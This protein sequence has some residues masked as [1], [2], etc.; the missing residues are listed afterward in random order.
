MDNKI[1]FILIIVIL[2]IFPLCS[3]AKIINQNES[4]GNKNRRKRRRRRRR[5]RKRKRKLKN[6]YDIIPKDVIDKLKYSTK[7]VMDKIKKLNGGREFPD[8][9][10]Q[11]ESLLIRSKNMYLN[12]LCLLKILKKQSNGDFEK[13][14]KLMQYPSFMHYFFRCNI[15]TCTSAQQQ[16]SDM[17]L[18]VIQAVNDTLRKNLWIPY[19]PSKRKIKQQI[20]RAK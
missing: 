18:S 1:I 5:K 17:G 14:I 3:K 16:I 20:E 2:I 6:K 15:D 9:K 7:I 12:T 8:F 13:A 11:S 4:F 19:I 10:N